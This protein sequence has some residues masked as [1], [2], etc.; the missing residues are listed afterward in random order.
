MKAN[1][2]IAAALLQGEK[3]PK[4]DAVV[5]NAAAA[6]YLA[7]AAADF[8]TALQMACDSIDNG[9]AM[10]KL[11]QLIQFSGSHVN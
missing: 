5:L 4:R 1:A 8:P 11:N 6:I 10:E 9:Y 7:E 3:G 2:E